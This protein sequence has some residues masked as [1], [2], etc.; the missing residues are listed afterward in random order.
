M[1]NT[2]V[3]Y[4]SIITM[5][6]IV[7]IIIFYGI[8]SKSKPVTKVDQLDKQEK[9]PDVKVEAIEGKVTIEVPEIKTT[10]VEQDKKDNVQEEEVIVE[11]E[12]PTVPPKPEQPQSEAEAENQ[13]EKE[14]PSK[15]V[16][17]DTKP[18]PKNE[19]V[20]KEGDEE[21]NPNPPNYEEPPKVEEKAVQEPVKDTVVVTPEVPEDTLDDR[22]NNLVPDSENPFLRPP[23]EVPSNGNRGERDSSNY[24]DGEW[25]TGDKF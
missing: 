2:K 14:T 7:T 1:K 22:G 15:P 21:E 10:E 9:Q 8:Y 25:G 12:K 16:E 23:S 20:V 19:D 24:G 11:V 3:K 17:N 18:I 5:L 6:F 4:I 13:T